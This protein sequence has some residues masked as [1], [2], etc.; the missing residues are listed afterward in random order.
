MGRWLD[1]LLVAAIGSTL[2]APIVRRVTA[3]R[4]DPFEPYVLFVLAYGVMF[5]VRPA[6]MLATDSRVHVGPLRTLDVSGTFTEMLVVA[7][8]GAIAFI[9]AYSLPLGRGLVRPHRPREESVDTRR[10][11]ILAGVLSGVAVA[12]FVVLVASVD[13]FRTL[14][15]IFRLGRSRDVEEAA[16]TY[17]YLWMSYVF[18]IP[19]AL[20]FLAV[21]LRTR[22]RA[23]IAVFFS[24]AVL[25][26]L[27]GIPLGQR[28]FL[29]PFL[30]GVFV[31]IYV[32]RSTRPSF[33]TVVLVVAVALLAST[34][35][36]DLRGRETRHESVAETVVRSTSPS[37]LADSVLTGPDTEMAATFALALSVVPEQ[38]PYTYGTTIFR[39]LVVR[40]IPR[41][42]WSGKPQVPRNELKAVLWPQEYANGTI[43]PEFSVLLYFYWDFGLL[44]VIVGMAA[45]GIGARYLYEYFVRHGDQTYAQV[46]YSLALWFVVI[47]LRDSPV[48]TIMRAAFVVAPVWLLF[49]LARS[50]A[51]ARRSESASAKLRTVA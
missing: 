42:L 49:R 8:L 10:L 33:R 32:Y 30:G 17:R 2:L 34:F 38:L 13:G 27:R 26:L 35:L 48:D 6:A 15:A 3:R 51:R 23:L 14:D 4:F 1:V 16:Q 19:A 28:M 31:L 44:G 9:V 41:S 46:L 36:S 43:N 11:L 7:W 40:P 25:V 5:V 24:L 29:L 50:H 45:Y 18:L 39:D 22:S 47:G 21:G 20:V 12:A 37:R